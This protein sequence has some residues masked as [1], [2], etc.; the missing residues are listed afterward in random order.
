MVEVPLVDIAWARS[1]DKGNAFNIGVI[2][3]EPRYLAWIGKA[4]TPEAMVEW[5]THEFDGNIPPEVRR[6]EMPG[7][8]GINLHFIDSLGGGQQASLRLDPLAKGKA[9]Q[10]LDMP[11]RI[12]KALVA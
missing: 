7:F 8:D 10:L 6:Y 4:L 11:V 3:R 9:Q 2:A 5:F 1:G 12:P